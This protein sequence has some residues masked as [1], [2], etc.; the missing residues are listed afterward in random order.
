MVV[1]L[2]NTATGPYTVDG[3]AFLKETSPGE[4][5]AIE[6]LKRNAT[7]DDAIVEAVGSDYTEYGRVASFTGIPT[8]LNWA[9]HE[10]Q[11]RGS[12]DLLDGI[13]E[14][15]SVI[16]QSEDVRLVDQILDRYDIQYVIFGERESHTYQ[17]KSLGHLSPILV[18]AFSHK[19]FTI[20]KVR[21]D[22]A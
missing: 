8:M 12:S 15:V 6:W 10:L 5:A 1:T 3:I 17:V 21:G 19:G 4:Y 7:V 16:Y 18:E 9:G 13:A 20:Y 2:G 11:W 22:D 14:D